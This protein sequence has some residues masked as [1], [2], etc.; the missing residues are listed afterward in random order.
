[1][2]TK[3]VKE[4]LKKVFKRI[5]GEYHDVEYR[6]KKYILDSYDSVYSEK[7]GEWEFDGKLNGRKIR[8][9]FF[10]K[11]KELLFG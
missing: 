6:G 9:Y 10:D 11:E 7:E 5:K 4:S 2:E 3:Y 8:D 1:M